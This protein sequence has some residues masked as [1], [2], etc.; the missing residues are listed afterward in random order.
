MSIIIKGDE[1]TEIKYGSQNIEYVYHGSNQIWPEE[2]SEF[3][4]WSAKTK[5]NGLVAPAFDPSAQGGSDFT[6]EFWWRPGSIP[7]GAYGGITGSWFSSTGSWM[8]AHSPDG[9]AGVHLYLYGHS[10]TYPWGTFGD[11]ERGKWYHFAYQFEYSSRKHIAWFNRNQVINRTGSHTIPGL[12]SSKL[13]IGETGIRGGANGHISNYRFSNRL[14]WSR[15]P[16]TLGVI[17]EPYESDNDTWLLAAVSEDLDRD[18]SRNKHPII[19]GAGV[20]PSE[21]NPFRKNT[22]ALQ[23]I[24]GGGGGG[25]GPANG[26]AMGGG[27]A[28]GF[29]QDDEVEIQKGVSY[30]I[31]VGGGGSANGN[32]SASS[33]KGG[34]V[35][36]VAIGGSASTATG[37]S[38]GGG[39]G[40]LNKGYAGGAGTDGQGF[41]GGAGA[42]SATSGCGGPGG[43]AAGLVPDSSPDNPATGGRGL[44]CFDGVRRAGGGGCA[45]ASRASNGSDGGGQGGALRASGSAINYTGSG[46]GG[47]CPSGTITSPGGTGATGVVL[48]KTKFTAVSISGSHTVTQ[49]A[50]GLNVYLFTGSGNI[51]F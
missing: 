23:I 3:G 40:K 42:G 13:H 10:D 34:L 6:V 33:F 21:D 44:E 36:L 1:P 45:Y 4:Y 12:N 15:P 37:G 27:G 18:Y 17:D 43:G 19:V 5:N 49:D 25:T 50:E 38:G 48:I 26:Y 46:G 29:L 30:T 2:Q 24:A 39:K 28:G 20:A 8:I 31:T 47:G 32:G 41:K 16:T 11:V 35:D 14:R 7:T 9:S 22:V 51:T